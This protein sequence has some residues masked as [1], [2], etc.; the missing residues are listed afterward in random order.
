MTCKESD[1]C[2]PG[3]V[4]V[5]VHC[6]LCTRLV[7]WMMNKLMCSYC[8]EYLGSISSFHRCEMLILT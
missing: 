6:A 3:L 2:S 7:F 5:Y 1:S 8:Q 4:M